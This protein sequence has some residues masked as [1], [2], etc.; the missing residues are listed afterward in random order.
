[1][2]KFIVQAKDKGGRL[3]KFLVRKFPQ[4]SRSHLQK[5]IKRGRVTVNKG[6]EKKP[7]YRLKAGDIIEADIEPLEMVSLAPDKTIPLDI[8]YEDDNLLVINKRA[9]I[10]V[11]AGVGRTKN[12]LVN[13]LIAHYPAI[14]KVGD[15]KTRPGI[16]HRLDKDVSGLM[17]VAK[18]DKS[19]EYLKS[20][21]KERKIEKNY[22]ALVRGKF[23]K[24]EGR[25]DYPIAPNPRDPRKM[26]AVQNRNEKLLARAKSALTEYKVIKQFD[27]TAYIKVYLRTGRRHQIRVHFKSIGHPLV[28][29]RFYGYRKQQFLGSGR[30]FLHASKLSFTSPQ[31]K[32]LSFISKLPNDLQEILTQQE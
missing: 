7:D 11:H 13:A 21:F 14:K 1:M 23:K 28:N 30:L 8:V 12:N 15:D 26:V 17:V 25:V 2:N 32:K 19:F 5:N 16:V 10:V 9:G 6:N 22:L 24:E 4:Y 18:N 27:N 29:D 3:D 20:L 31:G